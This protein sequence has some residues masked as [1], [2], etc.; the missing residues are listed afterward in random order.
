MKA[1]I[2]RVLSASV[3]V[4]GREVAAIDRGLVLLVGFERDD[5]PLDVEKACRKMTNFRIFEDESRKMNLSIKDI[6]GS[7]LAVPNFTLASDCRKGNRPSFQSCKE[8][9]QAKELFNELAKEFRDLG[10][11]VETGIFGAD[12][13]VNILNDGPATFIID[14]GIYG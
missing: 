5:T 14:R 7:I 11:N 2:Q 13:K 6:N 10:V 4:D 12:M 1:V 3:N 9:N 8:P